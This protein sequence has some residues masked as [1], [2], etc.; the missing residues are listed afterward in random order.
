MWLSIELILKVFLYKI[1]HHVVKVQTGI[2]PINAMISIWINE[3][4][5]VFVCCHKGIDHFH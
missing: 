4:V 3:K 2:A 1:K 5:K